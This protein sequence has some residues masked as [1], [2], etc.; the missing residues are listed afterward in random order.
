MNY[1]NNNSAF[2][3]EYND[4][5]FNHKSAKKVSI[6]TSILELTIA[7]TGVKAFANQPGNMGLLGT[8]HVVEGES[9]L[10]QVVL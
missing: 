4:Y 5:I 8:T 2:L 6:E 1:T 3:K 7:H 10:L 9:Q